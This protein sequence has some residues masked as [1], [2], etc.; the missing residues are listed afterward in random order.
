LVISEIGLESQHSLHLWYISSTIEFYFRKIETLDKHQYIPP[1]NNMPIVKNICAAEAEEIKYLPNNTVLISINEEDMDLYPLKIDRLDKRVLTVK[2]SDIAMVREIKG[3][4]YHPI[5][6]DTS[7]RILDFIN[8][9]EGKDFIVHC[10]AGI[11][12][13]AAIALY[14]NLFHGY[15]LKKRFWQTSKPNKYVIGSLIVS[16]FCNY[17]KE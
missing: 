3:L 14:L 16:R 17:N 8:K 10:A 15:E 5:D 2:F 7:L 1:I 9:N 6:G 13:S 12:R 11:S 4:T